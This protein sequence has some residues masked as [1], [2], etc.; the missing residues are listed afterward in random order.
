MRS[1]IAERSDG[2]GPTDDRAM[3]ARLYRDCV[4]RPK[5]RYWTYQTCVAIMARRG[6]RE[7]SEERGLDE[8]EQ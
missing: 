1:R 2:P 5:K 3:Y 7:R 4:T 6:M 8:D